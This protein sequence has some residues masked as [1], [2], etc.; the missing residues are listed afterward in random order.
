[1]NGIRSEMKLKPECIALKKTHLFKIL[2]AKGSVQEGSSVQ[3]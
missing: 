1:M 2:N 3:E